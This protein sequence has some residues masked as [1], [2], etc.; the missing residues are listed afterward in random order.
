MKELLVIIIFSLFTTYWICDRAK[1]AEDKVRIE[2]R[3]KIDSMQHKVDSLKS[4]LA[5]PTPKGTR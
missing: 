2:D 3:H 1:Q 4:K 5:I